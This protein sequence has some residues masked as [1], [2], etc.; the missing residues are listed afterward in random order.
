MVSKN[1]PCCISVKRIF[2]DWFSWRR[3]KVLSERCW[4]L[5]FKTIHLWINVRFLVYLFVLL[6]HLRVAQ[7][8]KLYHYTNHFDTCGGARHAV[9]YKRRS[10]CS[11]L[12]AG[13]W[14][15]CIARLPLE[16]TSP[17]S[18]LTGRYRHITTWPIHHIP[19]MERHSG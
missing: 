1:R 15:D 10:L 8:W 19:K 16:T 14:V 6:L 17:G 11:T 9:Q 3:V 2:S 5:L 4:I 13:F 12:R 18:S 7:L